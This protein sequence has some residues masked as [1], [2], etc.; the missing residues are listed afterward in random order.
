MVSIE[1]PVPEATRKHSNRLP[2]MQYR[3]ACAMLLTPYMPNTRVTK[4]RDATCL[5]RD[6]DDDDDESGADR[7]GVDTSCR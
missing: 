7:W 2:V 5:W 3:N 6:D 4:K 1:A